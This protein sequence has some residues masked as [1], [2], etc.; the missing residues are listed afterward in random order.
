MS[1][2]GI[3]IGA[4]TSSTVTI[5]EREF[6]LFAGCDYLGLAHH[7]RVLAAL[8]RGAARF[9]ISSAGSRHT[10]GNTIAHD[11][12]ERDLARFLGVEAALLAPD[13]Y[14]SN[15]ICAQGLEPGVATIL[16]DRECHVSVRDAIAASGRVARE[17]GF[18]DA[19]SAAEAARPLAGSPFAI[20]T[21]GV[22]PV[23]R[24]VAPLARLLELLPREGV[25]VVDDCHGLGVLGARGRGSVEHAGLR[26]PRIV[27]T[28]TLSKA[29]G[30]FGGFIAGTREFVERTRTTARAYAG[31]T[32]IPPALAC[33]AS[34]ALRVIDDEPERRARLFEHTSRLRAL[35][36]QLGLPVGV[37]A[38]P[39]FALRLETARR[40]ERVHADLRARGLLVPSV[41]YPDGQGG[42][43]RL[44][45]RAD[46]TDE[47]VDALIAGL[48]GALA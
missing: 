6:V 43:L 45:L 36:A 40:M 39:V 41:N 4:S 37:V 47:Q 34:E 20:F 21:D 22:F 15:L 11:E 46:H 13:G 28:G 26:D 9:G 14:L 12:L 31:S 42:Y 7:P 17:Y 27:V 48:R 30:C 33:A 16:C 29:L 38:F 32:P 10:T 5:D 2:A 8:E 23:L 19:R 25:L 3:S 24:E 1:I 35:F 18:V 44:A